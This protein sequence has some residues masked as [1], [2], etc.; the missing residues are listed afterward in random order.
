MPAC[1]VN[2]NDSDHSY[3]GMW[4][5]TPQKNRNYAWENFTTGN[6]VLFMDPYLVYYPRENRNLC[7]SPV[8]GIGSQAGPAL[9]EFPEQSRLS[10]AI[11]T[12][13]QPGQRHPQEF[14]LFDEVLPRPDSARRRG[15]PGLRSCRR[16]I[17]RGSFGHAELAEAGG[18]MVQPGD[19]SRP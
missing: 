14:S 9:G 19:R 10:P 16:L 11:F 13:A 5:D 4:N 1:K 6:Q 12:Q 8:N 7:L 17:H 3:F 2:I 18:R 15:V